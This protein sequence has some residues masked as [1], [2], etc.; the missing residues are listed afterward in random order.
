MLDS[1]YTNACDPNSMRDLGQLRNAEY[2]WS[3]NKDDNLYGQLRGYRT[4][5]YMKDQGVYSYGSK[6]PLGQSIDAS[7]GRQVK[8]YCVPHIQKVEDYTK[9]ISHNIF[10]PSLGPND[11]KHMVPA[12]IRLEYS[13]KRS[14]SGVR[15][16]TYR[17]TTSLHHAYDPTTPVQIPSEKVKQISNLMAQLEKEQMKR[18]KIEKHLNDIKKI[19]SAA[20]LQIP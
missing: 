9:N 3:A 15:M 7:A 19:V 16:H 20:Y 8:K 14:K 2:V 13:V 11:F 17:G 6:Q 18:Q 5:F 1:T 4:P 12:D 10:T